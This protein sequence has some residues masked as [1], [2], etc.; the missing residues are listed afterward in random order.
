MTNWRE[1]GPKELKENWLSVIFADNK[2]VAIR[3]NYPL[4]NKFN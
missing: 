2:A 1:P 4:S 3:W